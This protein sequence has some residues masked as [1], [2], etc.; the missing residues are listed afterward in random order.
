MF[1]AACGNPM[2]HVRT[3]WRGMQ[4]DLE[5]FECRAC[6]VSITQE[7]KRKTKLHNEAASVGCLIH[8]NVE[9]HPK[10]GVLD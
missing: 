8:F 3:I 4:A 6:G 7:Q 2:K 9:R 10:T 1:C 5:V